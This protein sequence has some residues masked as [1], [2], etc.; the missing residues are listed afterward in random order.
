MLLLVAAVPA[1]LV[2]GWVSGGQVRRLAALPWRGGGWVALA[3]AARLVLAHLPPALGATPAGHGL[4]LAGYGV[5][6][7]AL[8]AAAVVNRRRPGAGVFALGAGLNCLAVVANGGVM[9]YWIPAARWAAGNPQA[10][11]PR[12]FG[13]APVNALHGWRW[14]G[15]VVPLP[16]PWASV[17]SIGDALLALGAFWVVAR[18]MLE[19]GPARPAAGEASSGSPGAG[20]APERR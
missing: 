16:G 12:A 11:L 1:G 13:H 4:S 17:F 7:G 3:L 18:G 6:Y 20:S 19:G 2:W 5:A 14:L 9:P 8:G 15:D 10:S